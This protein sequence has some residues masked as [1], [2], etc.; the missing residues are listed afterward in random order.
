MIQFDMVS[1]TYD[2]HYETTQGSIRDIS[3][4]V[5]PGSCTLVCGASG[6]GK[7]TI[8]RLANGLAPTFYPGTLTGRVLVDGCDSETMESWE[9]AAVV[10]SV[11]QNPRTQFFNVDSTGEAAFSLE[12]L[13]WPED[14]LRKRT[15]QVI[16]ELGI[17]KLAD[18]SIFSLSG[19]EKQRIAF[20]S[21]WAP[22]PHNLV[23]DEPTSNLDLDAI[24][25]LRTYIVSAKEA[26]CAV[27]I[28]EHRL[29]WLA[30]VVDEVLFL[31]GG[32]L[33][34]RWTGEAFRTMSDEEF[35]RLGLRVRNLEDVRPKIRVSQKGLA[36][37]DAQM[38]LTV[39]N[40]CAGYR[41]TPIIDTVN[42]TL[43][44]GEITALVGPNGAG[45]TTLCRTLAGLHSESAG[46]IAFLTSGEITSEK[47][48]PKKRLARSAMV[49]QD[50][51]YQLFAPSVQDEV[52]FGL[53]P[54]DCNEEQV[55]TLLH[56][57]GLQGL[58][59]RHP[60]T[61]SGGQKQRLAVAAC[62]AASKSF[63]V[64]DEPTSGLDISA[65]EAVGALIRSVAQRGVAVL[66]V[67]HDLEFITAVCDRVVR[68]ERGM[69]A[70]ECSA[71]DVCAVRKLMAR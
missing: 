47:T 61:L 68:L 25:D 14:K 42:L 5:P 20:A 64:F 67:T 39:Q 34:H 65:M 59:R 12:S 17:Q 56:D 26:G 55:N 13:A 18:T 58:E 50:V 38:A 6:C 48:K 45:K 22:K 35:N 54:E 41:K 27:L 44:G 63:F 10:G 71:Q 16:E 57:L 46:S 40:L 4:T 2:T 60:A 70:G 32:K 21:A 49:F 28:A 36:A 53:S 30:D 9:M 52:T 3:F 62:L 29:W 1:F 11:F 7:T 8:T 15:H 24:E 19:G 37:D 31:D 66:V 33:V 23:L 43:R 69:T 51:N